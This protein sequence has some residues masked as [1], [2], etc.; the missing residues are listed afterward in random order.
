MYFQQTGFS[1]HHKICFQLIFQIDV[2]IRPYAQAIAGTPTFQKYNDNT[3]IYKLHYIVDK[4]IKEPT[5]IY[6]PPRKFE[7]GYA[8]T[9]F[10]DLDYSF[11]DTTLYIFNKGVKD[12]EQIRITVSPKPVEK[13]KKK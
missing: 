6:V 4:K 12:G 9:V 13:D 2:F 11:S 8:I 5:E 3:R 10:P 7:G 1:L